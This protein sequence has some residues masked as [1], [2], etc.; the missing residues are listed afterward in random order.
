VYHLTFIPTSVAWTLIAL[1]LI[2]AWLPDS[3]HRAYSTALE[4]IRTRRRVLF[5]I[6]IALGVPVA[7][8]I[9]FRSRN[10]ILGDSFKLVNQ[11]G[12][13][14]GFS[15]T[16]QLTV[17]AV[18][19]LDSITGNAAVAYGIASV[20]SGLLYVSIVCTFA[21]MIT[22]SGLGRLAVIALFFSLGTIQNFFA[23]PENYSIA[24]AFATAFL[25][26][27][28]Q[29]LREKYPFWPSIAAFVL[30]AAFHLLAAFLTPGFI[31]LLYRYGMISDVRDIA[32]PRSS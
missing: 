27:G 28:W 2:A 9:L 22:R 20:A 16:E 30:A 14:P 15:P 5:S 17:T 4:R 18:R 32:T 24:L 19:V 11:H 10:L 12:I 23:Y 31:Y 6:V 13:M 8:F 26:F 29:A 7:A 25:Y 3:A 1:A 21:L